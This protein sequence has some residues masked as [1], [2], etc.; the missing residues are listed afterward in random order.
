[1]DGLE[2]GGGAKRWQR[3]ETFLA[4]REG[5]VMSNCMVSISK[6]DDGPQDFVIEFELIGHC[7]LS[8]RDAHA[9][10]QIEAIA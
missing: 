6:Y 8:V 3:E 5:E 9:R 1:M 7:D 2:L 10:Q 4:E